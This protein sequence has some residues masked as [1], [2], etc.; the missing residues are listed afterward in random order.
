MHALSAEQKVIDGGDVLVAM[1]REEESHALYLLQQEGLTRLDLLNFISHGIA[2]DGSPSEGGAEPRH[3]PAGD[4]EDGEGETRKSP[5]EAYTTLLNEEAKQG[6]IDPLIGREKELE[7]TIQVLCRRRKNN[8]LYVGETGVGKT[9]IAEGLALHIHENR[10][11]EALKGAQVY[12]LDMGSL[13]AG[14]KFRGQFEE[15][16]KGVLK[17]AAGAPQRHPLHRRDPH[18]RRRGS[19]QRRLDGCV[20]H[21]Q[22]GA[23]QRAAALHRLDDVPGVQGLV[24]AGQGAVAALP[25]DRGR[26]ALGGGHR[27]HPRG[28]QEPLR[29]APRGEVRHGRGAR[30]GG[31]VRQAHQR[32]VPAG[33][34]DRRHRRDGRGRAAQARRT[35]APAR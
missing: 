27:A 14:T 1:F 18:H 11:P 2:K 6:R 13:L 20:Q 17:A 7:R 32:S 3:A 5:L 28:A 22:A 16:L 9:A 15:R 30:G 4:D 10:V 23:G 25:E 29:G 33:Q 26:R 21:P 35:S 31:A 24:R 34:G 19:H 8:P 12:S